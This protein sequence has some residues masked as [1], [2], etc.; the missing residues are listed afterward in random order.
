[1]ALI[2]NY[3]TTE[4][5]GKRRNWN[6]RQS[7]GHVRYTAAEWFDGSNV[8]SGSHPVFQPTFDDPTTDIAW[9]EIM[10]PTS[11]DSSPQNSGTSPSD[12]LIPLA[13]RDIEFHGNVP[14]IY[15]VPEDVLLCIFH[16]VVLP[17]QSG[18]YL[19]TLGLVCKH[20]REILESAPT[21]WT[22][23]SAG[24]SLSH[25]QNALRHIGQAPFDIVYPTDALCRA[26]AFFLLLKDKIRY[27]RSMNVSLSDPSGA[28]FNLDTSNTPV[29]DLFGEPNVPA[30]L[31]ELT[32]RGRSLIIPRWLANLTSLSLWGVEL[33]TMEDL[34]RVLQNSPNLKRLELE[35]MFDLK[36]NEA[37]P[38][39]TH[40]PS[41]VFLELWLPLAVIRYLLSGLRTNA[42]SCLRLIC[43]MDNARPRGNLLSNQITHFIPT[44]R[45][46]VS[47]A[48]MIH[49]EFDG[50]GV[51]SIGVGDLFFEFD[52]FPHQNQYRFAIDIFEL[53]AE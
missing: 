19:A 4:L 53:L 1:M 11:P 32:L 12:A 24:D 37:T 28:F 39:I 8:K 46:M 23:I 41:L 10:I 22:C 50:C 31:A 26:D 29:I 2:V 3:L 15:R 9:G 16:D 35:E 33:V 42:L 52:V 27:C 7:F 14:P 6:R 38:H 18:R 17:P 20:W 44:I 43:E 48:A 36:P 34:L 13:S 5:L 21:L 51:Y 49:F 45:E 30:K 25:V 47:R 40:L